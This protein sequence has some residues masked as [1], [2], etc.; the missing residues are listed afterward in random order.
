[1]AQHVI[2]SDT[3]DTQLNYSC[4]VWPEFDGNWSDLTRFSRTLVGQ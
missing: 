3:S 1:L 4:Y 2:A